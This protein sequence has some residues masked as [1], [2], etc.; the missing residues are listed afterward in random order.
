MA[1]RTIEWRVPDGA[2]PEVREIAN[3]AL[4]TILECMRLPIEDDLDLTPVAGADP[5]QARLQ[6]EIALRV[7]RERMRLAVATAR[8]K[9]E[10]ATRIREEVCGR[11]EGAADLP[12]SPPTI[13]LP[14]PRTPA[15]AVAPT[16]TPVQASLPS[17]EDDDDSDD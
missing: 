17:D 2:P 5:K 16:N 3:E 15:H 11:V 9:L 12:Q 10:A 7:R 8:L 13:V 14:L 4:D 1:R 6:V